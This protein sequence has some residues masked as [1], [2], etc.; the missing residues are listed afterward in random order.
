MIIF[1]VSYDYL[2]L[3]LIGEIVDSE[4]SGEVDC[5]DSFPIV[6]TLIRAAV[7]SSLHGGGSGSFLYS[8]D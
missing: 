1:I 6:S 3:S 5:L 7:V 4:E 8:T 2:R